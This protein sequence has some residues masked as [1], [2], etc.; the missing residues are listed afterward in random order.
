MIDPRKLHI[1]FAVAQRAPASDAEQLICEEVA[2]QLLALIAEA[3]SAPPRP[4]GV[5]GQDGAN[6]ARLG[7]EVAG[8]MPAGQAGDQ[9]D[10]QANGREGEQLGG[11]ES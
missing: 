8:G 9:R 2:E 11:G 7:G 10:G 6:A 5:N 4:D 1:L 3:A